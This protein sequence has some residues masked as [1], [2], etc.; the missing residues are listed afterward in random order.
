MLIGIWIWVCAMLVLAG[1][2]LITICG[3][4]LAAWDPPG[5]WEDD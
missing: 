2:G 1:L 4:I 3:V 5:F